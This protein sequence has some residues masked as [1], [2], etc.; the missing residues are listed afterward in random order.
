MNCHTEIYTQCIS[1]R[2]VN[3]NRSY[4]KIFSTHRLRISPNFNRR[5]EFG[6]FLNKSASIRLFII[7]LFFY[8]LSNVASHK[9]SRGMIKRRNQTCG[10][11]RCSTDRVE[12]YLPRGIFVESIWAKIENQ[13]LLHSRFGSSLAVRGIQGI[14]V[15]GFYSPAKFV[16]FRVLTIPGLQLELILFTITEVYAPS[17]LPYS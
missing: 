17:K 3:T 5:A 11:I 4:S 8:L 2:C 13:C 10:T 7:S 16:V 15:I 1:F 9:F 6:K 12:E 14:F